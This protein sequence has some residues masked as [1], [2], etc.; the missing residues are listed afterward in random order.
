MAVPMCESI[1]DGRGGSGVWAQEVAFNIDRD[2]VDSVDFGTGDDPYKRDW[3]EQVRPRFRL[4][5]WRPG[6]P[7]NWPAIGKALL[8][9]LVSPRSAG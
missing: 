9:K 7:R 4:T 6:D 1:T 2:R 3:M 8:R 5:C